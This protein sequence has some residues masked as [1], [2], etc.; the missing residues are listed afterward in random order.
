MCKPNKQAAAS[1]AALFQRFMFITGKIAKQ[2]VVRCWNLVAL[3]NLSDLALFAGKWIGVTDCR[4]SK[5][6]GI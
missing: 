2:F 5:F 6:D 1:V 3:K 4:G